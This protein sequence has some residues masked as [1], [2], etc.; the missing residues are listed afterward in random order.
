MISGRRVQ[1]E[2]VQSGSPRLPNSFRPAIL[3]G[4]TTD[5]RV[6]S[7]VGSRQPAIRSGARASGT[8]VVGRFAATLR[9]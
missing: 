5:G 3:S 8:I 7:V 9:P 6:G 4:G 1:P 2:D